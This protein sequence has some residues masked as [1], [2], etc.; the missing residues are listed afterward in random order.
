M[1]ASGWSRVEL[2][3]KHGLAVL[4]AMGCVLD[5]R[6]LEKITCNTQ[7]GHLDLNDISRT[8]AGPT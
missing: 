4:V 6:V 2:P 7:C 3:L 8:F 1:G 5:N